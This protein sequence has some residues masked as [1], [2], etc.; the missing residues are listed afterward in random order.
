MWVWWFVRGVLLVFGVDVVCG[1]RGCRL[2]L[3]CWVVCLR[4]VLVVDFW[5]DC[6]LAC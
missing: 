4:V 6:C 5:A 3:V 1:L 2:F